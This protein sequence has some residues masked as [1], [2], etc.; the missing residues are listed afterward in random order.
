ML[1]FFQEFPDFGTGSERQ[2]ARAIPSS[3]SSG[4]NRFPDEAAAAQ[5]TF[6]VQPPD[7][8]VASLREMESFFIL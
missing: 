2:M 5:A 4:S 3:R 6:F 1:F 7:D 8:S